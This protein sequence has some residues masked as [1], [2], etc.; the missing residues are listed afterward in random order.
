MSLRVKL[1]S[2]K[3]HNSIII[4]DN[5]YCKPSDSWGYADFGLPLKNYVK[6]SMETYTIM[7]VI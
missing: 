7:R 5:E 3:A 1:K 4:D 6:A 2:M